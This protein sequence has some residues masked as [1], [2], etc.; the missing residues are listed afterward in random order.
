MKTTD[1]EGCRVLFCHV[2]SSAGGLRPV[3]GEG[4]VRFYPYISNQGS[5]GEEIQIVRTARERRAL[6]IVGLRRFGNQILRVHLS[7]LSGLRLLSIHKTHDVHE[8]VFG[9]PIRFVGIDVPVASLAPS[10]HSQNPSIPTRAIL[11]AT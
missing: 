9:P 7:A 4:S 1:C 5:F 11:D 10:P 3:D 6:F 2:C 8:S